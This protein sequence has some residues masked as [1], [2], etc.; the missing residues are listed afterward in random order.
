MFLNIRLTGEHAADLGFLLHKHP[1][2][3]QQAELPVGKAHVFYPESTPVAGTC[4]VV[5]YIDSLDLVKIPPTTSLAN[6]ALGRYVNDRPYTASSLMTTA[7]A[8]LF[9]TAMNGTCTNKPHLAEKVLPLEIQVSAV[10]IGGRE[11]GMIEALF[12]PLGYKCAY[13]V[14]QLDEEHPSWGNSPYATLNLSVECRMQDLLRHLYVLLPVLDNKKH[15]FVG[16]DEIQK[17]IAKGEGWLETHPK[18][19]LIV[20]RYMRYQKGL[21]V[22]ANALLGDECSDEPD[23]NSTMSDQGA[24]ENHN[25]VAEESPVRLHEHRLQVVLDLVQQSGAKTVLDLGCGAGKFLSLA[26]TVSQFEQLVGMDVSVK[27]LELAKRRLKLLDT[28]GELISLIHGSLLYRDKRFE[29]FDAA[30]LVEVIEHI[31]EDVLPLVEKTVFLFANPGTVVVTTPNV[32]YNSQYELLEPNKMR[33]S[34][35]KFEWDRQQFEK[36]CM[37]VCEQ[38]GYTVVLGGIGEEVKDKGTPTQYGVFS[39]DN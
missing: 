29:G 17:L 15:Y 23:P 21:A 2:R 1:D 14:Q 7:I 4:C 12:E 36:W 18:R 9:S 5:L 34:D 37:R 20:D 31:H 6:F 25:N 16:E 13:D 30:V 19:N 38:F 11:R 35:H 22:R 24:G 10:A 28:E 27:A 26:R 3:L 32:E 39:R 8:K 33:H